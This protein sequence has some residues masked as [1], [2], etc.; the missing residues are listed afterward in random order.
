M[1]AP[2]THPSMGSARRRDAGPGAPV[3]WRARAVRFAAA[4]AFVVCVTGLAPVAPARAEWQLDGTPACAGTDQQFVPRIVSDGAGGVIFAWED[5]RGGTSDLYMQRMDASGEVQWTSTGRAV[6][7]AAGAQTPY[8]LIA[9]PAGGA[10]ACWLD[11][12][13]GSWFDLYA[14]RVDAS[15]AALWTDDGV[16]VCTGAGP[17]APTLASDGSTGALVTWQD[18]RNGNRDIF[19]QRV[20]SAGATRWTANGVPVCTAAGDQYGAVVVSDGAGGAIV[21]WVD[22]RSGMNDV[23][24]QRVNAAGTPLWPA[25]GIAL[26]S[27]SLGTCSIVPDG[28][29]G[30]IVAWV[31]DGGGRASRVTAGGGLYWGSGGV[32]IHA[33]AGDLRT[34]PA[35]GGGVFI[36]FS[37]YLA[38]DNSDVF[39]QKLDGAGVAYWPSSGFPVITRAGNQWPYALQVD[40]SGNALIYCASSD[41]ASY[42]QR[43]AAD[44]VL[45]WPLWGVRVIPKVV[46]TD[47]SDYGVVTDGSGGAIVGWSANTASYGQSSSIH[48]YARRVPA[49]GLRTI[50]AA[51][52]AGGHVSLLDSRFTFRD[53]VTASA[54]EA[55]RFQLLPDPGYYVNSVNLDG[56][57]QGTVPNLDLGHPTAGH[58]IYAG[59]SNATWFEPAVTTPRSAYTTVAFPLAFANDS[60][61]SVLGELGPYD[62]T[63]WRMARWSP[64]AGAY[65]Y[66]GQGFHT[67]QAGAGYWLITANG[68][69][70]QADGAPL[71]ADTVGVELLGTDASG[72]NQVANPYR[73]P[74]ADTALRVL[75]PDGLAGFTSGSNTSTDPFLWEWKGG[76]NYDSVRTVEPRKVYW[77]RKAVSAPVH[78][79]FPNWSSTVT[80]P[81]PAAAPAGAEWSVAMTARQGEATSMRV[82]AG[83]WARSAGMAALR[84]EAPPGSPDGGLSLRIREAGG[85]GAGRI[86]DFTRE[87]GPWRW[88][89][90]LSGAEA[91]GEVRLEIVG[92]DLPAGLRLWLSDDARDWRQEVRAGETVTLAATT[93][94][95]RLTFHAA[96]GGDLPAGAEAGA[97]IAT[98]Y[99]NPFRDRVGFVLQL[100]RASAALLSVFDVQGRQVRSLATGTMAP[101]EHVLVWD[102]RDAA[103]QAV[104]SGVYLARVRTG[105]TE[106]VRRILRIE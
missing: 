87:D 37:R 105:G 59:F 16:A 45:S 23:Y 7:T 3:R 78:L 106:L 85:A 98:A 57:S 72:W 28:S 29:G 21:A 76:S 79:V 52:S 56:V 36:A 91:P 42:L 82:L 32:L 54:L 97:S 81:G 38:A 19:V 95:R 13:G 50:R 86:A 71:T 70:V 47:P 48:A 94:V 102:G 27:H 66:A 96:I 83:R 39:V 43:V 67:L 14:Q 24:A 92:T 22:M 6:C 9:S 46:G 4:L 60:V 15:G 73:F 51:W 101:G 93:G 35:G 40:A 30:A 104:P 62:D 44:G 69:Q 12:R 10:V 11:T 26:G 75:G 1:R 100:A 64:E 61:R 68:A 31:D 20:D 80:S 33:G 103:G 5:S 58:T 84:L 88:E 34:A 55:A 18:S 41:S 90:E 63:A 2:C 77:V 49:A 25:N 99:P 53:S 17:E 8:G 65:Q 89:V 74:V